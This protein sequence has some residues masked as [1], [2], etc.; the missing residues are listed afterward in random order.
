MNSNAT[1]ITS[2]ELKYCERCGGLWLRAPHSTAVYC[3]PCRAKLADFPAARRCTRNSKRHS[4]VQRSRPY[5]AGQEG[6]RS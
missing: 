4:P 6:V 1:S 5:A 3:S 2:V